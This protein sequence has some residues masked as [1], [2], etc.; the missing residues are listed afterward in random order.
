MLYFYP[1]RGTP[2][3][4]DG[5]LQ[6]ELKVM[7]YYFGEEIFKCMVIVLTL[8]PSIQQ[9]MN[10]EQMKKTGYF[11]SMITSGERVISLAYNQ[12]TGVILRK[13]PVI[14]TYCAGDGDSIISKVIKSTKG[15][16]ASVDF[17]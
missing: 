5:A 7:Y 3:K 12:V 15:A 13:I 1:H 11:D 16:D 4:V 6:E 17:S 2:E 9:F 8:E 10:F 14:F